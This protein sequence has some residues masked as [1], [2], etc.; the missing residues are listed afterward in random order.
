MSFWAAAALLWVLL[1]A[2]ATWALNL[3][4]NPGFS[5]VLGLYS[6]SLNHGNISGTLVTGWGDNTDWAGRGIRIRYT[7][8]SGGACGGG[9]PHCVRANISGPFMQFGQTLPVQ[10]GR[11]YRLAVW[12]RAVPHAGARLAGAVVS[13]HLR[14]AGEPYYDYGQASM[15]A[16][17][18][19]RQLSITFAAVPRTASRQPADCFFQIV[20]GG[21]AT[22]WLAGASLQLFRPQD[23]QP[24]VVLVPP[25]ALP[26]PRAFFG[27]H[28]AGM[29]GDTWWWAEP[30]PFKH[31]YDW[32]RLDFG[33]FRTWD[34]GVM[35]SQIQPSKRGHFNFSLCDHIIERAW[36]R[37]QK[38]VF[39][40]GQTPAWASSHPT[41]PATYGL[42]LGAPPKR[43]A[44]WQAFVAALA[45]RY[46]SK[47]HAYEVW[48]EPDIQGEWGFFTGSPA[49]LVALERATA[50]VLAKEDPAALLLTPPMSGGDSGGSHQW[51][52]AYLAA[53]G[54]QRAQGVAWHAYVA[55]P[56]TA[57]GVVATLR[58]L[59]AAHGLRHLPVWN[60]EGGLD[61]ESTGSNATSA[62]GFVARSLLVHW[63]LQLHTSCWYSYNAQ[64]QYEGLTVVLPTGQRD[65]ARLAPA[66]KAYQQVMSLMLGA[67]MVSLSSRPDGT[68][69]ATLQ[70]DDG[71]A[72]QRRSRVAWRP[73]GPALLLL[74]AAWRASYWQDG[75][76]GG[77]TRVGGSK[78]VAVGQVPRL[79]VGDWH[80]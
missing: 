62:A 2:P 38:V 53:G 16:H 58:Q 77:V 50:D 49:D 52:N 64:P 72:S 60:T 19:W 3:L 18:S 39:T 78:S 40:L 71:S 66:G 23:P 48:N 28:A 37:R 11:A 51:M 10:G 14:Q 61:V 70:R 42:G 54:G 33:T 7:P 57:V 46:Q 32:P 34:S 31:V 79:I 36:K 27:L 20:A 5:P 12:V 41:Q 67:R 73:A 44:D 76:T 26:V 55:A 8:L 59:L 21:P 35:W 17:A 80:S 15:V 45:R 25:T 6:V 24:A 74:P 68:W 47:I 1:M 9:Q 63:A 65:P 56:E 13:L 69:V 4:T 29:F 30:E 75:V 43:L 22:V